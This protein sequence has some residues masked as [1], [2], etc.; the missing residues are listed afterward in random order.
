LIDGNNLHLVTGG[1]KTGAQFVSLFG[2]LFTVLITSV[3]NAVVYA[4]D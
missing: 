3:N 1:V 4:A 2:V